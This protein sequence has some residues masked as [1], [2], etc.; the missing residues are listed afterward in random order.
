MP[1]FFVLPRSAEEFIAA[2]GAPHGR[3]PL[4]FRIP[5]EELAPM[6]RSYV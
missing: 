5:T 4:C 1:A 3:E 6:G 2:V